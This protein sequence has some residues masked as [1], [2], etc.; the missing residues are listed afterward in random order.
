MV[1]LLLFP[2]D[3]KRQSMSI[4]VFDP[5]NQAT[6]DF[7]SYVGYLVFLLDF[8][9]EMKHENYSGVYT[10]ILKYCYYFCAIKL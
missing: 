9:F 3:S 5:P 2:F 4:A 8:L 6:I 7:E 10:K 1:G